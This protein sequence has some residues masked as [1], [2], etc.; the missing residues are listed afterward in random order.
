[1]AYSPSPYSAATVQRSRGG[2][3]LTLKGNGDRS[4]HVD[5]LAVSTDGR[6]LASAGNGP[7]IEIWDVQAGRLTHTLSGQ[8]GVNALAFDR[9]GKRLAV[10][11]AGDGEG[12]LRL[13]DLR[14]QAAMQS[15]PA[16]HG[17]VG[18]SFSPDGKY[19]AVSS[20]SLELLAIGS[21]SPVRQFRCASDVVIAPVF[22]ADGKLIAGNCRGVITVWSV[23]TGVELLHFGE[24]NLLNASAVAFSPSG[25]LLAASG[26]Q[27]LRIYDLPE[28]RLA[29]T[30]PTTAPVSAIA[31]SRDGRRIS[32][33]TRVQLRVQGSAAV[34]ERIG[35]DA[36]SIVPGPRIPL[37]PKE[38]TK[39]RATV[40][41]ADRVFRYWARNTLGPDWTLHGKS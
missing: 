30:W 14:K 15:P 22:S 27:D 40:P 24:P 28:K 37:S 7:N 2:D 17:I 20:R 13:W 9:D 21:D 16:D 5:Q 10:G 34:S 19:L 12:A 29:A 36:S 39:S 8:F 31:F 26:A 18:A 35:L 23:D 4:W 11:S 6:W 41:G 33:G 1:M 38:E 3:A 32:A 25:K